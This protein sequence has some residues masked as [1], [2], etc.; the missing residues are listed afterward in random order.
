[1]KIKIYFLHLS[2]SLLVIL[3]GIIII[4]FFLERSF[5][6]VYTEELYLAKGEFISQIAKE[7][8][9]RVTTKQNKKKNT[10][11]TDKRDKPPKREKAKTKKSR[12]KYDLAPTINCGC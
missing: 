10:V 7:N 8:P 1:M 6:F 11:K 3:I 9:N 5:S 4:D 2:I 12:L